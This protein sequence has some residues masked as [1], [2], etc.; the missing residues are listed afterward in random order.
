[1]AGTTAWNE[2]AANRLEARLLGSFELAIGG[3]EVRQWRGRRGLDVLKYVLATP[4]RSTRRD[5]L[6]EQFWPGVDP[7]RARNRLQVAVSSVR[8]AVWAVADGNILEH[9]DGTYRVPPDVDLTVDVDRFETLVAEGRRHDLDGRIEHCLAAYTQAA[10]LYRG[11]FLAD[12]PYA[13]WALVARESLRMMQLDV[14]DRLA[15]L[16]WATGSLGECVNVAQR[17]LGYDPCRE[18]AHRL[19]MRI[20]AQHGHPNEVCRQYE[21]CRL[22]VADRLGTSP[23]P[24]TT[25]LYRELLAG[26]TNHEV[27]H[28]VS[29][30]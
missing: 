3:R 24:T 28:D 8:K 2:P 27:V 22:I 11:N 25:Q 15:Q 29:P 10:A 7:D 20:A 5:V 23:S 26:A 1:M 30:W 14:L 13:D 19:L 9:A 4:T 6:I 16:Y 17:I 21:L 12:D 18:D